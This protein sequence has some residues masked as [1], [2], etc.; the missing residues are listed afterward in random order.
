MIGNQ[1]SPRKKGS[2]GWKGEEA[3]KHIGAV[4]VR[5]RK[6][7]KLTQLRAAE[8]GGVTAKSWGRYE[9]G[10]VAIPTDVLFRFACETRL[11]MDAFFPRVANE[12]ATVTSIA[13]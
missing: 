3:R 10:E 7:L 2:K 12:D 8:L 9:N 4:L 6:D 1:N 13:A 5:V 11:P